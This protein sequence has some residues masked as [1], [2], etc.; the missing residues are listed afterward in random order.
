MKLR[1]FF[2]T[3]VIITFIFINACSTEVKD[4]N[5]YY[6]EKFIIST[7]D[8]NSIHAPSTGDRLSTLNYRNDLRD[9]MIQD[10]GNRLRVSQDVIYKEF[11]SHG[12]TDIRTR[13]LIEIINSR[14]NLVYCCGNINDPKNTIVIYVEKLLR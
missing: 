2:L 11:T 14:G 12:S 3:G 13:D 9:H 7:A 1:D 5:Y 8:W 4:E 10:L 6:C